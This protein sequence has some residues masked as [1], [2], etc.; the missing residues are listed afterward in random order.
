MADDPLTDLGGLAERLGEG[1]AARGLHVATVESC[2]GGLVGHAI[3]EVPGSSGYFLGGFVTYSDEL[4]R[5]SVGVP[6]RR[7]RGP[8]RRQRPGRDGD[9]DRR[10]RANRARTSR[11]R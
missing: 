4:K 5:Q 10:P 8:R 9:G 1:C 6:G 2:T 11:S 7:P 3:T